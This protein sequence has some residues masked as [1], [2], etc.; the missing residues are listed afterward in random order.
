VIANFAAGQVIRLRRTGRDGTPLWA[1]R[2][3]VGGRNSRRVQR[4]GFASERDAAEALERELE[5]LR[6]ERRVSRSLTLAELVDRR[7][8]DD[9]LARLS[10]RGNAGASTGSSSS[11]CLGDD[12][13]HPAKVG[14][15]NPTPRRKE[16]RPFESWA[17]V[18]AIAAALGPRYG[19]MIIFAAA[20][21]L[22][23]A[24]WVALE[25]RDV[26]R[27]KAKSPCKS[28]KAL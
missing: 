13:R 21:G 11:R 4:G 12:R 20:T 1:Y 23:P 8:A 17:E 25:K 22:R 14:V 9:A 28:K 26:D 3:R 6:R 27:L 2:Y 15:D 24:E 16:Q 18:E 19:P 5:R 10:L 7:V